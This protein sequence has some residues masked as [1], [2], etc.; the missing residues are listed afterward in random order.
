[1]DRHHMAMLALAALAL[2]AC[3]NIQPDP[4]SPLVVSSQGENFHVE[5]LTTPRS[6]VGGGIVAVLGNGESAQY[7]HAT[8]APSEPRLVPHF[9]GQGESGYI[10]YTQEGACSFDTAVVR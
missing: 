9:V 3:G 1:M 10:A 6:Y 7:V 4:N 5:Y 8:G 2:S